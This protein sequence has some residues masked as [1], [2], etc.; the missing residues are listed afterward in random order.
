MDD[1][2]GIVPFEQ[3]LGLCAALHEVIVV[4]LGVVWRAR[5]T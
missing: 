2:G 4:R 3:C 5:A 1:V